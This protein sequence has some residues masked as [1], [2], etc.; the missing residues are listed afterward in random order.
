MDMKRAVL[1]CIAL[2]LGAAPALAAPS[3]SELEQPRTVEIPAGAMDDGALAALADD[4]LYTSRAVAA[5]Y[6]DAMGAVIALAEQTLAETG[7]NG[8]TMA[9]RIPSVQQI[10]AGIP[11]EDGEEA[12]RF[13][14]GSLKQ[15]TYLQDFKHESTGWRVVHGEV[16]SQAIELTVGGSE[17]TRAGRKEDFVIIQVNPETGR[18]TCLTMKTYDPETG[19]FTAEFP[20]FGPYMI[21]QRL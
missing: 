9:Q 10:F 8:H 1:L 16:Q 5:Q 4:G 21:T 3:I 18:R 7:T 12:A 20:G 2:C 17:V 19:A 15:L 13:D 11:E 14:L 6:D